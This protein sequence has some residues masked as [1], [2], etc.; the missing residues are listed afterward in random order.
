V[1]IKILLCKLGGPSAIL[2]S[3][4]LNCESDNKV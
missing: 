4:W 1:S 2:V 3:E